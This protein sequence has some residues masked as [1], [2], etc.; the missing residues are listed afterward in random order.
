LDDRYVNQ[1]IGAVILA[2]DGLYNEGSDPQYESKNFKS[3]IYTVALGDTTPKR[4]LLIGNVNYNKTAFLGNDFEVE[5]LAEAYQSKGEP[6]RLP[7]S[8]DGKKAAA[9]NIR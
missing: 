2:T 5:V 9:K 8:E 4:D 1:N 7:L 3:I 6:K